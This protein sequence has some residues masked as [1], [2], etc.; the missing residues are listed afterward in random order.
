MELPFAERMTAGMGGPRSTEMDRRIGERLRQLREARGLRARIVADALGITVTAYAKWESGATRLTLQRLDRVAPLLGVSALQIFHGERVQEMRV[1][2]EPSGSTSP[3]LSW[4]SKP[5]RSENAQRLVYV[6]QHLKS[7]ANMI[8]GYPLLK[9]LVSMAVM[10]A[11]EL[12]EKE[13]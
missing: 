13:K 9:H 5:A 12:I 4:N 8:E 2:P 10:E 6:E 7:L 11:R 3:S 1:K